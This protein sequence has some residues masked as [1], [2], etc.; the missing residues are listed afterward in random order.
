MSVAEGPSP[1]A[2]TLHPRISL[3]LPDD[4]FPTI[5]RGVNVLRISC[6]LP[7][8]RVLGQSV[9][10]ANEA[11]MIWPLSGSL[12]ASQTSRELATAS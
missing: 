8:I 1:S 2:H 9:T 3:K 11:F 7:V 10:P 12:I 4:P 5:P 6:L